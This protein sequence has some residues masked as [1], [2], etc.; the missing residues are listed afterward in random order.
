[1]QLVAFQQSQQ[2]PDIHHVYQ[3]SL[4]SSNRDNK[5]HQFQVRAA[6]ANI[7]LPSS[8]NT[9]LESSSMF[10]SM[11]KVKFNFQDIP[12]DI[13]MQPVV[14]TTVHFQFSLYV[15]KIQM[16]LV[17]FTAVEF[18]SQGMF[19]NPDVACSFYRGS[20]SIFTIP[21]ENPDVA[22]SF[23]RGQIQISVYVQ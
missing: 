8:T 9:K 11:T 10:K 6:N 21:S 12:S 5:S 23:Y 13:Q 19:K 14:L 15:R 16:Q 7:K 20:F 4:Q 17:V 2:K 1:M 22:C 3:W 18:K